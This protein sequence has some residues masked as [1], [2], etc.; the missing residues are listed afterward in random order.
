MCI[1]TCRG[2]SS[3]EFALEP[4][5]ALGLFEFLV[6]WEDQRLLPDGVGRQVQGVQHARLVGQVHG[7]AHE[8]EGLGPVGLH[9][10]VF[11]HPLELAGDSSFFSGRL[12]LWR[13]CAPA[14]LDLG[15][16][17]DHAELLELWKADV[18]VLDGNITAPTE[19]THDFMD[20]VHPVFVMQKW[21]AICDHAETALGELPVYRIPDIGNDSFRQRGI[22]S[23][24]KLLQRH[25]DSYVQRLV[26]EVQGTYLSR[27]AAVENV[28]APS[29]GLDAP[30]L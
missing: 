7:V 10:D 20:N 28:W 8:V 15:Q 19:V 6:M 2:A 18:Q 5:V 29:P 27:Q 9:D 26:A 16:G 17:I 3:V 25:G 1:E 12:W 13:N 4:H 30:V 11:S 22:P 21:D 23:Q 14:A 24:V